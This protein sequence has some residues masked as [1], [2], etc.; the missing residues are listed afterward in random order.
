MC[1]AREAGV[2]SIE[3]FCRG[4]QPFLARHLLDHQNLPLL[5]PS[6]VAALPRP[7][8]KLAFDRALLAATQAITKFELYK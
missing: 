1:G 7:L 4:P 6:H 3:A 8:Q 2:R 5:M